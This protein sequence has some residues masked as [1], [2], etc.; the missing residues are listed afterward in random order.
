MKVLDNQQWVEKQFATCQLGNRLRSKRL[1]TVATNLLNTPEATVHKQ[2]TGWAEQKAAYRLFDQEQVTFQAVAEPHWRQTRQTPPGRCLLIS[3]T[4][5]LDFSSRRATSGLGQLGNGRGR[6]VQLHSCLLYHCDEQ[7]IVGTAGALLHY[8]QHVSKTET[9]RQRLERPRESELWGRLVDQV[10]RPPA[11]CQW[12]HVFDRGGDNFEAMCHIRLQQCDWVIRA[13][14]LQRNVINERGKKVALKDELPRARALGG[15]ELKLRSRP[16]V[17]A[18]TAQLTVSVVPVTL[19][20]P[21]HHSHWVKQC[22]IRELE[23]NVVIVE[24]RSP[25]RGITPIRWILFTNLKAET[26]AEARQIV[27]DYEHRWLIEE[28]HKVLKTGC[29]ANGH[30]LRAAERLEPLIGMITVVGTRLL[31]MKLIG[32][33]QPEAKAATHVPTDWLDCLKRVFPKLKG[34]ALTVYEFFRELAKLGG[35][36]ARKG[37]GEP[38]WQTVW[39][40]Y[41]KLR[42][43][44]DGM[45]LAGAK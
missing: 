28:Y 4:T 1:V 11:G 19:P 38:G 43:L 16:G 42:L 39:A 29:N 31:Q 33:N 13:S 45:K 40:G 37:D 8:R 12:I 5:D 41:Q 9:R 35:F 21:R 32:R 3:D 27:A 20:R 23:L 25:P 18:R 7:Q 26:Y 14:K 30:S 22:G 34:K 2:N 44:L 6:G 24:E 36:S 17:K 10:G 15:Y